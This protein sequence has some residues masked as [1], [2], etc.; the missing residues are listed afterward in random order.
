[1]ERSHATK[2]I[3][4]GRGGNMSKTEA[5]HMIV[6]LAKKSDEMADQITNIGELAGI[7]IHALKYFFPTIIGRSML[8]YKGIESLAEELGQELVETRYEKTILFDGIRLTQ[9]KHKKEIEDA[10]T[11]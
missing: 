11:V 9:S 4:Y 3:S 10:E 7:E 1:M 8:V 2:S 6:D 5:M